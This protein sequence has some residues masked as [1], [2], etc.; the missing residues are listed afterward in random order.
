L[1]D[2]LPG[3]GGPFL[4]V[5]FPGGGAVAALPVAVGFGAGFTPAAPV[6]VSTGAAVPVGWEWG[7]ETAVDLDALV[8]AL[9]VHVA[10]FG[11]FGGGAGFAG[12]AFAVTGG[13]GWFPVC[14]W[15]GGCGVG[16]VD[17]SNRAWP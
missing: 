12:A 5:A 15:V 9:G 4:P 1:S 8:A 11:G 13:H 6:V 2:V 14:Q 7:D 17:G 3:E 10:L 16:S